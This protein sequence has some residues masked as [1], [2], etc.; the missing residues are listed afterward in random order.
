VEEGLESGC[1]NRVIFTK[2]NGFM[3]TVTSDAIT[4]ILIIPEDV[5][6]LHGDMANAVKVRPNNKK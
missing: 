6:V 1:V 4:I 3:R 2:R 5:I